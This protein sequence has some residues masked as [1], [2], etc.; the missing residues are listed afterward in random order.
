MYILSFLKRL[1]RGNISKYLNID[2]VTICRL[3][4]VEQCVLVAGFYA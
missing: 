3:A 2:H 4:W 1:S